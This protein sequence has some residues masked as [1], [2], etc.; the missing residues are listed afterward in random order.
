MNKKYKALKHFQLILLQQTVWKYK[1]FKQSTES[2]HLSYHI[3]YIY[4]KL[5]INYFKDFFKVLKKG[6]TYYS[7]H[8]Y[9][10]LYSSIKSTSK[11][12]TVTEMPPR[13]KARI[14]TWWRG[15]VQQKI[16]VQNYGSAYKNENP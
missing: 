2:G 3:K 4:I 13:L 7:F 1:V 10:S 11:T 14:E 5:Q 15:K 12:K 6:A 8:T 9:K 16:S